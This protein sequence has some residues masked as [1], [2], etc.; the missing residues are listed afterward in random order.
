MQSQWSAWLAAEKAAGRGGI[1]WPEA[2]VR[3]LVF[4]MVFLVPLDVSGGTFKAQL[5][6]SPDAP[7]TALATFTMSAGAFAAG[8]CPVTA[9][10]TAIATAALPGD[11]DG[12][13]LTEALADLLYTPSGAPDPL[14]FCAFSIP[15][16]GRVTEPT[17]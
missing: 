1:V 8:V 13:G 11:G 9:K 17:P 6:A 4:E 15:I 5:R 7:G 16:S 12:D 14:R 10:L 3:G 2:I